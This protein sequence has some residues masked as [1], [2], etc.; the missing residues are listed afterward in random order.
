MLKLMLLRHAKTE[1]NSETGLD[2]D[3]SL[4]P[5][6]QRQAQSMSAHLTEYGLTETAV[7][8]SDAKRTRETFDFIQLGNQIK[9]LTYDHALYLASREELLTI[10]SKQQGNSLILLI[11]H[12]DGLSDLASYLTD[13]YLHLDTCTLLTLNVHVDEWQ[14]LSA[15]TCTIA[16]VFRPV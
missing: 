16:E 12:N 1:K 15:G 6:G 5:K 8:C 2:F 3:R 13:T 14:A 4:A 10:L 7:F 9:A 11:G